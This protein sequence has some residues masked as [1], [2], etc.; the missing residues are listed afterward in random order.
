MR[1]E[2][3][4]REEEEKKAEN[5]TS[6]RIRRDSSEVETE[7]R[8]ILGNVEK[9]MILEEKID[10]EKR[11][12]EI[13]TNMRREEEDR[14]KRIRKARNLEQSWEL[15]RECSKFLQDNEKT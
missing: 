12:E 13:L 9:N 1:L 14:E 3:T 15:I 4:I 5:I 2:K 7:P 11:R 10:W 6:K 8:K